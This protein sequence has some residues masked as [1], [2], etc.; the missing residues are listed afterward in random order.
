MPIES[1][2][3]TLLIGMISGAYMLGMLIWSAA[4][5]EKRVWPPDHATNA[6][7]FRVWFMTIL[8][9]STA[10]IL[11]LMDWNRFEWPATIR[12][13]T[14]VP[15]ILIGNIVVWN[16]VLK[17]GMDATSGD[18]T[19]LI[20]DG[21]YGWSRNP[22]YVADIVILIGWGLLAASLWILPILSVGI[23]VLLIAPLAE[24]PWLVEI[25]GEP[26]LIYKTKVRRYI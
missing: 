6:I 2:V 22:Q 13:L 26:Y 4:Y 18:A 8:I 20:T 23:L 21:L 19:G 11:G 15:L 7:K 3:A 16:G 1:Y 17:I 9:F 5:P 10:F 24:E 12:W 25:Y 14:G